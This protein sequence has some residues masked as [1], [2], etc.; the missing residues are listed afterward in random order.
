MVD[1]N[2]QLAL[3]EQ[4]VLKERALKLS[5]S[6]AE[7]LRRLTNESVYKDE[8]TGHY[9]LTPN[10]RENAHK[11]F[12]DFFEQADRSHQLL[13]LAVDGA[14]RAVKTEAQEGKDEER[15]DERGWALLRTTQS[16]QG[17]NTWQEANELYTKAVGQTTK[18]AGVSAANLYQ[19]VKEIR[20]QLESE[21]V[22]VDEYLKRD[23]KEFDGLLKDETEKLDAETLT[24][25]DKAR[26]K[27]GKFKQKI[28]GW[29]PKKQ[30]DRQPQ[31]VT[32]EVTPEEEIPPLLR[33]KMTRRQFLKFAGATGAAVV[34]APIIR[35]GLDPE[36]QAGLGAASARPEMPGSGER[37]EASSSTLLEVYRK[38][39][40]GKEHLLSEK[41]WVRTEGE[42]A[43]KKI[44]G[45]GTHLGI[46]A[47]QY[48]ESEK[49]EGEDFDTYY[50]RF[51]DSFHELSNNA[52]LDFI[53]LVTS[54]QI[55][56]E[57]IAGY[58][59][60]KDPS[61]VDV[62]VSRV[63]KVGITA[64][65]A[66]GL[67][68]AMV[69]S[70]DIGG[71]A[72]QIRNEAE[73]RGIS[74][75]LEGAIPEEGI[76][77][78]D[79]IRFREQPT[80]G[81]MDFEPGSRAE[82]FMFL[83]NNPL[84][85]MLH[86]EYP[87]V[88]ERYERAHERREEVS[89]TREEM[90]SAAN[91]F[92]ERH[93]D[94]LRPFAEGNQEALSAIGISPTMDLWQLINYTDVWYKVS[95]IP[96]NPEFAYQR[97]VEYMREEAAKNPQAFYRRLFSQQIRN[98]KFIDYLMRHADTNGSQEERLDVSNIQN[99][100]VDYEQKAK[101][102]R[103]A[104]LNILEAEGQ[105][106]YDSRFQ[107]ATS[108]LVT[109]R[110]SDAAGGF[111]P[112][113]RS[114]L[115]WHIYK[116]C[117][118]REIAPIPFLVDDQ[119]FACDITIDPPYASEAIVESLDTFARMLQ[120]AGILENAPGN[121]INTF[122][123][124]MEKMFWRDG[125]VWFG[126]QPSP[127]DQARWDRILAHFNTKLANRLF[128]DFAG[129]LHD[130]QKMSELNQIMM[131]KGLTSQPANKDPYNF[132]TQFVYLSLNSSHMRRDVPKETWDEAERWFQT[133]IMPMVI[134]REET[135]PGVFK[136]KRNIGSAD[137][138]PIF[139]SQA[140]MYNFLIDQNPE[141]PSSTSSSEVLGHH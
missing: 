48:Y 81:L 75:P 51:V 80:T 54:L 109:N 99:L 139:R 19:R 33:R 66:L 25:I 116:T 36:F 56:A 95:E 108:I 5:T 130:E 59:E 124:T 65:R 105:Y 17:V 76:R 106:E 117:A 98:P 23:V 62:N 12:E 67:E 38:H 92:I 26:E 136:E 15:L 7:N 60:P 70:L 132:F 71:L 96:T 46:F 126:A 69:E 22:L 90:E 113:D 104:H 31:T 10:G 68:H 53:T 11:T 42:G 114:S 6:Y 123:S 89:R 72:S 120:E 103:I 4:D 37:H 110:L 50:K 63:Q 3:S 86:R 115:G 16:I 61:N 137:Y 119:P 129:L 87:Q 49:R 91:D 125:G 24:L 39:F 88:C 102:L 34:L 73:R 30:K 85:E 122:Y 21:G 97:T 135:A 40:K 112:N 45:A 83:R 82:A 57:N 93:E 111:D 101:N 84:S 55:S 20:K 8:N 64:A 128:Y 79:L 138:P 100:V 43:D 133:N 134:T 9:R 29:L 41:A 78:Y 2:E 27:I 74:T 18:E 13:R 131:S 58:E 77:H 140:V 94:A 107:Q 28:S 127:E 52:G 47:N 14:Y 35:V 32:R 141:P 118:A 44:R 121:D 1:D